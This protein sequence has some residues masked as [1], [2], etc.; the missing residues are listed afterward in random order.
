MTTRNARKL[1][2]LVVTKKVC[3]ASREKDCQDGNEKGDIRHDCA[4]H[5]VMAFCLFCGFVARR[6]DRAQN[7]IGISSRQKATKVQ[8]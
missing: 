1:L 2:F 5:D 6:P 4:V 7:V 8:R 3:I